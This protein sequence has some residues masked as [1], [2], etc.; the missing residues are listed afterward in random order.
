MSSNLVR[1]RQM[2]DFYYNAEIQVLGGKS[3]TRD[4][5]TWTREN[6]AEIRKGR[7]EWESRVE[8]LQVSPKRRGPA[9]ARFS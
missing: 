4:G 3:I 9:L 8:K 2:R 7:Q 6:L 5:R 1:A